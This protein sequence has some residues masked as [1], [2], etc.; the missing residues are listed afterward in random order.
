MVSG[1]N[2]GIL[3]SGGAVKQMRTSLGLPHPC[4]QSGSKEATPL[5]ESGGAVQLEILSAVACAFLIEMVG[6]RGMN[7]CEFP[8]RSR[9]KE[10]R[11]RMLAPSRWLIRVLG[12]IDRLATGF[13]VLSVA[14]NFYRRT[15]RSKPVSD[16]NLGRSMAAR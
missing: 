12:A 6:G 8:K 1:G 11:H 9:P 10:P 16:Q 14:N 7:G 15:L 4:P 13:L 2:R 3:A 5:G